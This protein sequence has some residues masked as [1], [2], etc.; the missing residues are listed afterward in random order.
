MNSNEYMREYML[1]RYHQRRKAALEYLGGK[2]VICQTTEN[3]ELDH[4]DRSSKSIDIARM[5]SVS[6][7]RFWEEIKKCQLLCK[8]HHLDKSFEVGDIKPKADHGS[9]SLYRRGCRCYECREANSIYLK[10][11]RKRQ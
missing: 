6:E 9:T 2:C 4:I 8:D 3:L 11:Y 1:N 10:E 5:W 7:V